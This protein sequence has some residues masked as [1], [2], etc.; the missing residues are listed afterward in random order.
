MADR[1]NSNFVTTAEWNQF[2]NL[3]ADELY[4]LVTTVFDDYQMQGP[5]NFTTGG[6]L[7]QAAVSQ[8]IVYVINALGTTTN[9][10][11]NALGAPGT[12]SVGQQFVATTTQQIPGTGKVQIPPSS[13]VYPMPDGVTAFNDEAGNQI[14]PPPIYKLSGID[15]GLNNA[16]NGFVTVSKFNFIVDPVTV[17]SSLIRLLRST[18][19]LD[20]STGFLTI[21]YGLSPHLPVNSPYAY[22]GIFHV[23]CSSCRIPILVRVTMDGYVT[24]LCVPQ[25][26]L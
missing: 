13:A 12:A 5:I 22:I 14:V 20:C 4:D 3:A 9:A 25:N 7:I 2:L 18:E 24:L 11:W 17:M 19:C 1:V 21:R 15:L 8:S 16:P 23:E 10:Q 6:G 26:T